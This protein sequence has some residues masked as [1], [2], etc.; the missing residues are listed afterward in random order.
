MFVSMSE[1][2]SEEDFA[3]LVL[4][5]VVELEMKLNEDMRLRWHVQ[6]ISE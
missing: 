2:M 6:D 3:I 4:N 5:K 1:P